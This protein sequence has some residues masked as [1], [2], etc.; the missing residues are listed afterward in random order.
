MGTKFSVDSSGNLIAL[1]D[2]QAGSDVVTDFISEKTAAHGVDIDALRIKDQTIDTQTSGTFSIAPT[3]ATDISLAKDTTVTGDLIVTS[4]VVTDFISEKTAAHGVDIDALR[5]K[6]TTI[7]TQVATTLTV[8]PTNANAI[9]LA[10]N[11]TVS[12]T[13]T[14][15]A[16]TNQLTLG[17]TNTTTFDVPAPSASRTYTVPDFGGTASVMLAN[18]SNTTATQGT[19]TPTLGD[20]TNDFTLSTALGWY[21]KICNMVWFTTF[22]AWSSKGSATGSCFLKSLPFTSTTAAN[23]RG[24]A[25]ISYNQGLVSTISGKDSTPMAGIVANNSQVNLIKTSSDGAAPTNILCSDC[26]A[27]GSI[28]VWGFYLTD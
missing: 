1:G 3:N 13:L 19:F 14:A 17:T 22:V 9:T 7:D 10:K 11:T 12:G 21:S 25:G 27:T 15:T 24:A 26:S 16:T 2:V 20:A 5:I 4:D 28:Q 6:D 8:G 18:T 23:Y